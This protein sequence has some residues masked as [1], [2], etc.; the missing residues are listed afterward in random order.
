MDFN[1]ASTY[2]S[3]DVIND[4]CIHFL[5]SAGNI[6]LDFLQRELRSIKAKKGMTKKMD[7]NNQIG[8]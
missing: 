3:M 7:Y 8:V 4:L 5:L 2:Y 1:K 6:D